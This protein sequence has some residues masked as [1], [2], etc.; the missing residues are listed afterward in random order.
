MPFLSFSCCQPVLELLEDSG[1]EAEETQ[2]GLAFLEFTHVLEVSGRLA[3]KAM[4]R[5][6]AGARR[7]LCS[8]CLVPGHATTLGATFSGRFLFG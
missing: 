8:E 6:N 5:G 3:P 4:N 1:D 2:Q 7:A